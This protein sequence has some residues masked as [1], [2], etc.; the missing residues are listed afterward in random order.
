MAV[1]AG[2]LADAIASAGTLADDL[3]QGVDAVAQRLFA[4][5]RAAALNEL[6]HLAV[7]IHDFRGAFA[8]LDPIGP[9]PRRFG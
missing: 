7:R 1:P 3:E 8:A 9:S 5:N 4:G 2:L 6:G